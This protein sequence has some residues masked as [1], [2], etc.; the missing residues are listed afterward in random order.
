MV[1]A[2]R[3]ADPDEIAK[4]VICLAADDASYAEGVELFADGGFEQV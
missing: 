3:V 2:G 1:P 4:V